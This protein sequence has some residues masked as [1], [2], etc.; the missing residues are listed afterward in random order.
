MSCVDALYIGDRVFNDDAIL[1]VGAANLSEI[2]VGGTIGRDE[3]SDDGE[4]FASI[5]CLSNPEEGIIAQAI[6]VEV[7]ARWI[8]GAVIGGTSLAVDV[9]SVSR[10][11]CRFRVCLPDV[12]LDHQR[13]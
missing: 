5:D 8:A 9:A 1:N 3:L 13:K 12:H 10:V 11:C 7:A 2:T 6:R 4:N